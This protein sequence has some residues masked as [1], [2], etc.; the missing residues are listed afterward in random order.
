MPCVCV[1]KIRGWRSAIPHNDVLGR[2]GL[3]HLGLKHQGLTRLG[4]TRLGLE[5]RPSGD[6]L[7]GRVTRWPVWPLI[8][9][10]NLGAMPVLAGIRDLTVLVDQIT[11]S[12]TQ[13]TGLRA[14][15]KALPARQRTRPGS[16]PSHKTNTPL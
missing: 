11:T 5:H 6:V 4:L 2:Q 15:D 7:A 13:E 16:E 3:K 8:D 1:G 12:P 10:G 14:G 9:A